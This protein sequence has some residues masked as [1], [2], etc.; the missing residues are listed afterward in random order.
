[1]IF[2]EDAAI[3]TLEMTT[4]SQE[5]VFWNDVTSKLQFIVYKGETEVGGDPLQSMDI[6]SEEARRFIH[7]RAK[8]VIEEF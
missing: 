5:K 4:D 1:M 6:D 8:H 2:F 3:E 7:L